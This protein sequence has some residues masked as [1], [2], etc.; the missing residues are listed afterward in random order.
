MSAVPAVSVARRCGVAVLVAGGLALA[1]CSS[2]PSSNTTTTSAGASGSGASGGSTASQLQAL[3]AAVQA[4]EHGTYK[5]VY[6]AVQN[7]QTQTVT[8]EQEPPKSYFSTSGGSVIDTGTTTYFCSDS[9]GQQA[10]VS[11]SGS[12]NPLAGLLQLFSP[13]T[14]ISALQQAETEAAAHIAGV[15]VSFSSAT[16]AGQ[17]ATC[18]TA[19]NNGQSG[20]YCVTRSGLLAYEGANGNSF[21]LTSF[22]ASVTESDFAPPAG[23]SVQTIPSIP[24]T[25]Y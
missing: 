9:S 23:A 20:K 5:A 11:T 15:S 14:A 1:G 21:S 18:V 16:F 6:T 4:E 25:S 10:C 22:S 17:D 8:F 13:A 3:T 7:G 12:T 2:S 19:S 24:S